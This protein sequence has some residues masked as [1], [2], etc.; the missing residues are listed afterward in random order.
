MLI[1]AYNPLIYFKIRFFKNI[2]DYCS[3][4]DLIKEGLFITQI[5]F[6]FLDLYFYKKIINFVKKIVYI[7]YLFNS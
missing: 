3:E 1:E 5:L 4:K 6:Y 2:E 7:I